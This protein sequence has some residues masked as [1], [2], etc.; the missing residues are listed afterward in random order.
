MAEDGTPLRPPD[1]D[2]G[3]KP[4]DVSKGLGWSARLGAFRRT[5]TGP[6]RTWQSGHPPQCL[7]EFGDVPD[8]ED[9]GEVPAGR[10]RLP[11][12][13]RYAPRQPVQ[14]ILYPDQDRP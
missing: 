4:D 11:Y 1:P 8:G 2:G 13:I 6:D 12:P 3:S 5:R 9:P 7:H 10:L 14:R